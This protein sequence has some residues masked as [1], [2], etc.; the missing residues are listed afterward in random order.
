MDESKKKEIK[1]KMQSIREMTGLSRAE[2]CRR[3]GISLRTM[4]EWESGRRNPPDYLPRLL[5][6]YV[7]A[8]P[9]PEKPLNA[10]DDDEPENT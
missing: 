10:P 1:T 9:N 8:N 5:A 2:F 7:K 3:Y 4:E 6:Y